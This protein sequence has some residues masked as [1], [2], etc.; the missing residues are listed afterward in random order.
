[1]LNSY[2]RDRVTKKQKKRVFEEFFED[3]AVQVSWDGP[4]SA[5]AIENGRV[6]VSPWAGP[7]ATISNLVHSRNAID[8]RGSMATLQRTALLGLLVLTGCTTVTVLNPAPEPIEVTARSWVEPGGA[9][10]AEVL[11][12]E[13]LTLAEGTCWISGYLT[14]TAEGPTTD[15]SDGWACDVVNAENDV[16][17]I[18]VTITCE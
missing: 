3:A 4:T 12:P 15:P 5:Q 10:R 17:I 11:C 13:G 14:L 8:V 9:V 18:E 2:A 16:R 1:M 7:E 6:V